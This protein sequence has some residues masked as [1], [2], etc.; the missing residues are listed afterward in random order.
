MSKK[1]T[2]K[3]FAAAEKIIAEGAKAPEIAPVEA[4]DALFNDEKPS[5]ARELS[6]ELVI[7]PSAEAP[8]ETPSEIHP[9]GS[10]SEN[11]PSTDDLPG[12]V[13][14]EKA[15]GQERLR[16]LL[17][18]MEEFL[19]E[20]RQGFEP[21]VAEALWVRITS[22]ASIGR[23]GR[24]SSSIPHLA[25]STCKDPVSVVWEIASSMPGAQRKEVVAA[26]VLRGVATSTAHT[27]YQAW[28]SAGK[29]GLERKAKA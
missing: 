22:G 3:D 11:T 1:A 15:Y 5:E 13:E 20:A 21:A 2:K 25:R 7:Q 4:T 6:G 19:A 14:A 10:V 24:I 29:L 18:N 16:D 12:P 17:G 27:Q 8:V 9:A 23:P 28:R 26:C